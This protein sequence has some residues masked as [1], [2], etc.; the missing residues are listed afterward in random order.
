ML[1]RT[2]GMDSRQVKSLEQTPKHKTTEGI[3]TKATI[4]KRRSARAKSLI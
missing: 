2:T 1:L 4:K 3:V